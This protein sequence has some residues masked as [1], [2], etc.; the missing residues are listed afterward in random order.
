ME[1]GHVRENPQ[2]PQQQEA[3]QAITQGLQKE[4]GP[5]FSGKQSS[6]QTQ[7]N[8]EANIKWVHA[9]MDP[10]SGS[11]NL[12]KPASLKRAFLLCRSGFVLAT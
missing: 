6:H 8:N 7:P 1:A 11:G 10:V 3:L 4:D 5:S 9:L 2:T 12:L